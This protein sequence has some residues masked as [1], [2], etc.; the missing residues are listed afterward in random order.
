M[1]GCSGCD[2]TLDL[3]HKFGGVTSVSSSL[4][5]D[6]ADPLIRPHAVHWVMCIETYSNPDNRR[7][8]V[9]GWQLIGGTPDHAM[10]TLDEFMI[11]AFRGTTSP[12]DI[13]N[14]IQLSIPGTN[15]AFDKASEMSQLIREYMKQGYYIECTGHSLGGAVAKCIGDKFGVGV[16]T[17]N[18]AAPPSNPVYSVGKN[19]IHYHIVFDIISAWVKSVRIDKK[20]R[21]GMGLIGKYTS[22]IPVVKHLFPKYTI[23]N[24]V[25]PI[26]KA[27]QLEMFSKSKTGV[28]VSNEYEQS[29]WYDWYNNLPILTKNV[30]LKFIQSPSLPSIP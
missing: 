8:D 5:I 27:H 21:P 20:V 24:S 17:F 25:G 14:D 10:Y 12:K 30:F 19:Q 16:V 11:V 29:L 18:M 2:C 15:C 3:Y 13:I 22:K 26:L 23:Q 1:C 6:D 7:K 9:A 4:T 28:L